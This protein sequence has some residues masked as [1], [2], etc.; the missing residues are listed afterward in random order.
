[1]F[2]QDFIGLHHVCS[3]ASRIEPGFGYRSLYSPL[4]GPVPNWAQPGPTQVGLG[5]SQAS[6]VTWHAPLGRAPQGILLGVG[7]LPYWTLLDPIRGAGVWGGYGESLAA[8]FPQ[9]ESY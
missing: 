5:S 8:G 4:L 9:L 2:R 6:L 3:F 7:F 1:M